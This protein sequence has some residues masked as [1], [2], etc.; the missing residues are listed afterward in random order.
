MWVRERPS[1]T[2]R[3]LADDNL[4]AMIRAAEAVR[5]AVQTSRREP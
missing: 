2:W 3:H 1:E 4:S 5:Q